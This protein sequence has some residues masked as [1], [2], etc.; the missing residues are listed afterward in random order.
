MKKFL[1]LLLVFLFREGAQAATCFDLFVDAT[2]NGGTSYTVGSFLFGQ[3]GNSGNTWFALTNT[4]APPATG[5]P[6]IAAGNLSYPGLPPSTGNSVFIPASTGVMGRLS[7]NFT[8][9]TGAVYF[10]FL[11][12]VLDL[13]AVDTTGTQNNYFAGFGDTIGSQNATLLRTATRVYTKR[14]GIGFKLG[15][16]RN[17]NTPSDWVFDPTQRNTNEV[18]FVV[19]SYDYN[20]HTA[21]LWINPPA[22]AFGSNTAPLPTITATGGADLNSNGIRAFVLGCRTNAPPSCLVDELHIGTSWAI[23]TGGLDIALQPANQTQNAG[24]TATFSATATGAPPLSYQW[25]KNGVDLVNNGKFSGA[26]SATLS[27]NNL[28]Q[29]DA[30]GYSV[31]ITNSSGSIVSITATLSVNDPAINVQPVDQALPAGTNAIFQVVAGGTAPLTYQWFKD[32]GALSNN[33]HTSGANTAMLTIGNISAADVGS[34]QARVG[35]GLGSS[36]LSSNAD[37]F[38]TDPSIVARRP[39]II[40]ILCDDL[41]YGDS[42]ILFQNN[43]APGLPRESTPN[44]D[45][46]AAEGIQLLRHYC[47]APVCAPSRASLLLGLHQGHA[48]V[49][50]QQFDKALANNHTL[51]SVLKKAGYATAVIGKW[52]L[53]GDA[54]GGTIPAEWPAYPIQRGFD[55]FFGY[56]RHADGHEHYPK[57]AIYSSRS[58]ECYDGTNNI[59]ASLDKCYTTDLFTARAKKWIQ[60]QHTAQ[61]G[62]PFFLY[63]AFDTP[64]SVYELPTQAYPTGGGTGGGL[65]WLGTPGNMINTASGTVDSFV[66]P[67]YANATYDDDGNPATPEVA[68]PEVFKRYAT[69]VRRIDGAVGDI[70]KLLQDLAMDTNTIVVFTSDNG[71]TI[72]D[73][74]SLTPRYSADFFDNF[75]PMDGVKRDTFEGGIRM[76]TFVRWPGTIPAGSTNNTPSQFHDW[77]PTFTELAGLPAPA[78]TD[79][80]SLIPT[81]LGS[82]NQRPGTVYVEYYDATSTPDYSEFEPGHRNRTRNQMQV[83]G[84]NGY[85]GV[86]YD[87]TSQTNDFEIYDVANDP[88]Q[89]TNLATNPAFAVLQQQMKDQV[90]Q[91]RRP[92][93]EAPRPYDAE[94]VPSINF[95]PTTNGLLNFAVYEGA[96]PWVPDVAMLT[97]ASTGH[98]AGLD[99]T[100]R[101]RETNYAIEYTGFIRLQTD[102]DYTFYLNTDAG[103]LLR[104]HDATVI[105]DDFTHTN[106]EVSAGIKLKAGLHPLRLIYRHISGTNLL[107]LKYSGPNIA[108]QSVPITAFCSTCTNCSTSPV[109]NDDFAIT[110]MATPIMVNLLANDT[111]DGLPAPLTITSVSQ[112]FAGNAV[113][114][115]GQI[116]YTPNAGFLG[117]DSFTYTVSDGAA[118][119]S[120]KVQV[121]VAYVDGSYWFPFNEVAGLTTTEAGGFAIAQ[122]QGF[123]NDPNQWVAGRYNRALD[124]NGT[125]SFVS[126]TGFNGITGNNARTC[127]AW[128]KTTAA[129][130]MSIISWGPNATGNKWTFLIQAGTVCLEVTGGWVQGSRLINDGQWHHVACTFQNDGT[131][132]V[133]D[134]KLYVDGTLESVSSSQAQAINTIFMEAV[135]IGSD[136]QDRFFDGAIDEVRVYNRALS[137]T[138]IA[139][140]YNATNQSAAVWQRR[141]FGSTIANWSA[142]NDGD[143]VTTLGE[144]A[145]GGQPLIADS[146]FAKIDSEISTH[147][148]QIQFN[149]RLTGTHEL[150]YQIQSSTNL[151]NWTPLAGS[152][153]STMPLATPGFEKVTFRATQPVSNTSSLFVRLAVQL[154]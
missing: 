64:H 143:G 66:H 30:G 103:A 136:V 5:F 46:F 82:G 3:T 74:L 134:V 63:L 17:S 29:A 151:V 153:I 23:V 142:D 97:T 45:A 20:N 67:D 132:D 53:A 49:R 35:N 40:Y 1:F 147:H 36:I 12:K 100:V 48:N 96:W 44:L 56:V 85:Q 107:S 88:K 24:T 58:K 115:N 78:H 137:A 9:T 34:Y 111:D 112:P 91:L 94:L 122:L 114:V 70:K 125:N 149:R 144:Y 55:Y 104:L 38:M 148:L 75:G 71:P 109:P 120:A 135:K 51:G 141:Y 13:S 98:V 108:K 6:L 32:G 68:W 124:F 116:R 69:S 27:I 127:A 16:A 140:L 95:V 110:S 62:K 8:T 119:S 102:G 54:D 14:S 21:N 123:T 26:N 41:G 117:E 138:E 131:P 37:L 90:L 84:L 106:G 42:G 130:N 11:L 4:P 129:S 25:R 7:L 52:G 59:V 76:P 15:V 72:E 33:G 47:P 121:K 80:V 105:D 43:R 28:I 99:L 87:I 93:A 92:D 146:Q 86:R 118:Q 126:I 65:Q 57:E 133:T 145:F 10:S 19:G 83:I 139:S 154:P 89:I 77:M 101:T 81:L 79:G 31:R 152:V 128:I 50:D 113:I 22:T 60:D 150:T 2:T 39:N 61:P 73:A 18:L